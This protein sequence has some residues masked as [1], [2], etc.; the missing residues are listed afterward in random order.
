M[1]FRFIFV[2]IL[3]SFLSCSDSVQEFVCFHFDQRQCQTDEFG[4]DIAAADQ[5][6]WGEIIKNYLSTKSVDVEEVFVNFE[7]Y[8][9]VCEACDVC[10]ET[11]RFYIK[12]PVLDQQNL[13][14][15]DLMSLGQDGCGEFF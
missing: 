1:N 2:V 8:D 11:H 12:I 5:S 4:P 7:H 10:P 14:N 9:A 13:L 15:L 6:Q 3:F